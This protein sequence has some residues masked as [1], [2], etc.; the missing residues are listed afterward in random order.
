[1]HIASV[2]T[3]EHASELT[4]ELVKTSAFKAVA[5][6]WAQELDFLTSSQVTLILLVEGP[7]IEKRWYVVSTFAVSS[8]VSNQRQ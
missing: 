5:L 8:K 4:G 7:H 3:F 1:M 6:E 2:L